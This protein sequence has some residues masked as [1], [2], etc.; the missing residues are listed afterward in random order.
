MTSKQALN[1][2][3]DEIKYTH[4]DGKTLTS[5]DQK[6]VDVIKKDLEVLQELKKILLKADRIENHVIN[7]D[8][9]EVKYEV[10]DT[11]LPVI[12]VE[13]KIKEWLNN[14]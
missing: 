9:D 1:D 12:Y 8:E 2:L 5:Y 7:Q 3:I 11:I 10:I 6:R 13:G 4:N 14:E